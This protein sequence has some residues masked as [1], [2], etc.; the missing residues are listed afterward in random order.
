MPLINWKDF[1]SAKESTGYPDK[2]IMP[3]G[4]YPIECQGMNHWTSEAMQKKH[5]KSACMIFFKGKILSGEYKGKIAEF[6]MFTNPEAEGNI[7]F[8]QL[9]GL[10]VAA[11]VANKV[12]GRGT[13]PPEDLDDFDLKK[14]YVKLKV[15]DYND[16]T[17]NAYAGSMSVADYTAWAAKKDEEQTEAA[18]SESI[19]EK[20]DADFDK[21]IPF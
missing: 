4:W 14:F 8:S 5:S 19:P 20:G 11:G 13:Y 2:P 3:E 16:K 6:G 9:T 15:E 12:E 10:A 7:G 17:Q 18:L 1:E 21:Q